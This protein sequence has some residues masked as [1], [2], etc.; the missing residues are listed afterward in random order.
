VNPGEQ[1]VNVW[2]LDAWAGTA[3]AVFPIEA[4]QAETL[5]LIVIA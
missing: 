1:T 4:V 5:T 2:V 3:N